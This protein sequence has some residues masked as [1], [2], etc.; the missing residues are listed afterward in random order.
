MYNNKNEYS[1][2][3]N[4]ISLFLYSRVIGVLIMSA[5]SKIASKCFHRITTLQL[6]AFVNKNKKVFD[7]L[8][9]A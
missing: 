8:A 5:F 6:D 7:E 2:Y 9:K 1:K 3:K 4:L